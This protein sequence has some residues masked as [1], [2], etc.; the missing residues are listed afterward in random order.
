[1]DMHGVQ[2]VILFNLVCC[3]LTV[4]EAKQNNQPPECGQPVD[5]ATFNRLISVKF[6]GDMKICP[7]LMFP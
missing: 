2:Q 1:M 4:S 7:F 5:R 6:Y 3:E